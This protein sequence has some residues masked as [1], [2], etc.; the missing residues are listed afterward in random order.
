[1]SF[2]VTAKELETVARCTS[3][4][5]A[6]LFKKQLTKLGYTATVEQEEKSNVASSRRTN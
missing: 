6:L 1:M 2:Y 4:S 3:I 5:R